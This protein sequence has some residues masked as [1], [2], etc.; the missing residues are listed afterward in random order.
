M[1]NQIYDAQS[2]VN[3]IIEYS[4]EK[5]YSL[6]AIRLQKLLYAVQGFSLK[7]R[8][9]EAFSNNIEAWNYGPVVADVYYD[10]SYKGSSEFTKKDVKNKKSTVEMQ[11]N[12]IIIQEEKVPN[13]SDTELINIVKTLVDYFS[14]VKDFDLV[15]WSHGHKAWSDAH[16]ENEIHN[17]ITINAIREE[18]ANEK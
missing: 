18:F 15:R 14:K 17:L 16:D 10:Y 11:N 9:V 8:G 7:F 12:E 2:F 5:N 6:K 13:V 3:L 4:E 1:N